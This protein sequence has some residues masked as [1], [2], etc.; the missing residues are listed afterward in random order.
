M[1]YDYKAPILNTFHPLTPRP[2]ALANP[3]GRPRVPRVSPRFPLVEEPLAAGNR[4]WREE[5]LVVV[6]VVVVGFGAGFGAVGGSSTKD[7]SVVLIYD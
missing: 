2:R 1:I 6:V 4:D 3:L 7:I 5:V